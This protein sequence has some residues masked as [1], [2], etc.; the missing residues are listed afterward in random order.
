MGDNNR[1]YQKA[2]FDYFPKLAEL[3][4]QLLSEEEEISRLVSEGEELLRQDRGWGLVD[5]LRSRP[6]Q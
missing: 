2:E 4:Y 6:K 1:R 3:E 5:F